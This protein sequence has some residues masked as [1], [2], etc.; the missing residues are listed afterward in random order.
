MRHK[1]AKPMLK[2]LPIPLLVEVLT[3]GST[4][5]RVAPDAAAFDRAPLSRLRTRNRPICGS[6]APVS[7]ERKA[8]RPSSLLPHL[9]HGLSRN[10]FLFDDD[11]VVQDLQDQLEAI[12]QV[13][14]GVTVGWAARGA[15]GAS[16]G[17][18]DGLF[19]VLMRA[20]LEA[21]E[22]VGDGWRSR[23]S[24]A[25]RLDKLVHYFLQVRVV[26]FTY[27]IAKSPPSQRGI[28][29]FLD[30]VLVRTGQSMLGRFPNPRRIAGV[31]T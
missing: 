1:T 14:V 30:R 24:V 7:S 12:R 23:V 4:G 27:S 28:N 13:I 18:S 10:E 19:G 25:D 16:S 15:S 31:V 17:W 8:R 26:G 9:E 22:N 6:R 21:E 3:V 29:L 2:R 20:V 11:G 5:R